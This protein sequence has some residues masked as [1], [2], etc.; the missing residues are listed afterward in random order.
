MDFE[1]RDEVLVDEY[2]AMIT[3]KTA[4][5]LSLCAELG[6]LVAG[7]DEE[8]IANYAAFGLNLGL[9]FQVIDDILGIW[10]DETRTGKSAATDIITKKKTLPVLYGL[11]RSE[12]MRELYLTAPADEQFVAEVV[13]LLDDTGCTRIRLRYRHR[14]FNRSPQ[15]S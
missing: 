3:G 6:A 11:E 12:L 7:Q 5:L 15:A 10:G 13:T 14:I 4:V 2:I 9:A 8:T 1:T